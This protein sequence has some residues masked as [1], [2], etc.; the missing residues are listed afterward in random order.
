MG[1]EWGGGGGSFQALY[2]VCTRVGVEWGV[3]G[4][5]QALYKV[6][7]R[8]G[9]EWGVGGVFRLFIRSAHGWV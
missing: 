1:V 9:V 8:V 7:T 4:S 5:F 6:C 3:G 2:K